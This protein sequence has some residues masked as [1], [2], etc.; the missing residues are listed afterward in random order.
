MYIFS[1]S[2]QRIIG[3]NFLIALKVM[4][5]PFLWIPGDTRLSDLQWLL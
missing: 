1:N 2:V 5:F 3:V 4:R